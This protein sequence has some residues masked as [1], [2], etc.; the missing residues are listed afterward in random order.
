MLSEICLATF[1]VPLIPNFKGINSFEDQ[2]CAS[3][4]INSSLCTNSMH[5]VY[6]INKNAASFFMQLPS[7]YVGVKTPLFCAMH[8]SL[9]EDKP[10]AS[11]FKA[12][13]SLLP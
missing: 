7:H 13:D 1:G 12:E 8:C 9:K 3:K 2:M 5:F 11:I 6:V 4:R 10:A